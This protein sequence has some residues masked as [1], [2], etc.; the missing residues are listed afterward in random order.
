MGKKRG[1]F[2]HQLWILIKK[3]WLIQS[4]HPYVTLFEF[5]IPALLGSLLQIGRFKGIYKKNVN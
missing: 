1:G 2:F 4:R 3:N 5:L